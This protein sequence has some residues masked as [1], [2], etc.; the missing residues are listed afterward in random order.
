MAL[1]KE[2]H[3]PPPSD[4]IFVFM[5]CLSLF[6]LQFESIVYLNESIHALHL[7]C[8]LAVSEKL[9]PRLFIGIFCFVTAYFLLV[10]YCS[11]LYGVY[12][13][14]MDVLY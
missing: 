10:G 12:L 8:C 1:C 14:S 4:K 13:D 9:T 3:T 11:L 5:L 7:R 6:E 2:C